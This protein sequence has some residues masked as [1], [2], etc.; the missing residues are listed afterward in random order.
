MARKL[1]QPSRFAYMQAIGAMRC[2]ALPGI[3]AM[4]LCS[5]SHFVNRGSPRTATARGEDIVH[6][7]D[8]REEEAYS[9][10]PGSRTGV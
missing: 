10:D 3:G 5:C 9:S 8:W 4:G 2:A 7:A 1:L 6:V